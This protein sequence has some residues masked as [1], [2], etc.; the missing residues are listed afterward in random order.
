MHSRLKGFVRP[1]AP[2]GWHTPSTSRKRKVLMQGEARTRLLTRRGHR[3]P[4]W[5][6]GCWACWLVPLRKP[7][8]DTRA[9]ASPG[10]GSVALLCPLPASPSHARVSQPRYWQRTC[11]WSRRIDYNRMQLAERCAGTRAP[12]HAPRRRTGGDIRRDRLV[13]VLV[14]GVG[15]RRAATVLLRRRAG[16]GARVRVRLAAVRVRLP[17]RAQARRRRAAGSATEVRGMTLTV[18]RGHHG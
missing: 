15:R 1:A 17:R 18:A 9:S 10:A 7:L 2:K 14:C 4:A 13:A 3:T 16:L 11:L 8:P 12:S 5:R 6:A